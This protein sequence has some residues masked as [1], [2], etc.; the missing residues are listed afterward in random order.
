[1]NTCVYVSRVVLDAL[2]AA[3]VWDVKTLL[4]RRMVTLVS[5]PYAS[6]S[7]NALMF[8]LK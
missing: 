2:W 8:E 1:M 4:V 3:D 6:S 5:I 7:I